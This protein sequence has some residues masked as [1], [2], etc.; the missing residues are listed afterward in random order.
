M[1]QLHSHQKF[2]PQPSLS[3]DQQVQAQPLPSTFLCL[4][5]QSAHHLQLCH[6]LV[7]G[8]RVPR[9]QQEQNL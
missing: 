2:Q 6:F 4:G 3:A 1:D 7:L 9:C 8:T 5:W